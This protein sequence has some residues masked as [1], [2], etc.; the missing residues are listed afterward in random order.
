MSI[1]KLSSE[2]D[3]MILTHLDGDTKSFDSISRLSHYYRALSEPFLYKD[4]T[5]TTPSKHR[6][7]FLLLI[8]LERPSL[9]LY[10][11]K[12]TLV[13]HN[14][15]SRSLDP[16]EQ[17]YEWFWSWVNEIH[18]CVRDLILDAAPAQLAISWF[19]DILAEYP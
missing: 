12:V 14:T 16:A 10:I 18:T 4:L 5:F 7:R 13:L 11:K 19:R 8:L 1:Q 15:D 6:V 3:N 17:L 9:A 2:L